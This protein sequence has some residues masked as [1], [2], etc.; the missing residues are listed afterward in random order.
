M[1]R[2][3]GNDTVTKEEAIPF[4][5]VGAP[6]PHF[7]GNEERLLLSYCIGFVG[8]DSFSPVKTPHVVNESSR[9]E[10]VIVEFRNPVSCFLVPISDETFD[11]HPLAR[12]GLL[13]YGVYRIDNSSWKSQT[14]ASTYFHPRPSPGVLDAASHYVFAFHDSVFECIADGYE[15][16]I[17]TASQDGVLEEMLSLLRKGGR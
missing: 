5:D 3:T 6:M 4:P 15:I 14:I 16:R 8:V 1:Y 11:A 7:M 13:P 9:S 2:L 12:R 10:V 17:R